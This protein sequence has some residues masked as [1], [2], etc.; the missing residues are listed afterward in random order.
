MKRFFPAVFLVASMLIPAQQADAKQC[1][2]TSA[3]FAAWVGEFQREARAQG[4]SADTLSAALSNVKYAT[5]TIHL[6]RTQKTFKMS[7]DEFMQKRGADYIIS[8]GRKLKAQHAD[9]FARIEAAFGVPAGPL[10]AIWGM[11]TAFG[12]FSG[13]QDIFSP[14]ATL[15]YDC[16]RSAFFEEQLYAALK[17]LQTAQL[18]RADMVG[19]GHGEIGQMQFLPANYVRYGV[20]GDGNGRV[21]MVGSSADALASTA[22]YLRSHGWKKGRGYQPGET[23]FAAIQEWNKA[24]VYQKAIASIGKSIDG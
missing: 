8:R 3:G 19:A 10:I 1:G 17:L 16:R 9:L 24:G 13:D 7:F 18:S 6:D 15:A 14:L 21:D 5:R 11:E 20:D 2:N 4:I 23:N 22:N 12:K